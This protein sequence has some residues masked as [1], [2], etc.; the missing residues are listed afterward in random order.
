MKG[1]S[2]RELRIIG[3]A[4]RDCERIALERVW[5]AIHGEYPGMTPARMARKLAHLFA[6]RSKMIRRC[7]L[8]FYASKHVAKQR[9]LDPYAKWPEAKLR[10]QY[11]AETKKLRARKP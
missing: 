3:A 9:A 8:P 1:F 11:R 5:E 7:G 2:E 10:R 4:F 6:T